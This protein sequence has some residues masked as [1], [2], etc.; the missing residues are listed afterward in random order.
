MIY[1]LR[2]T[3]YDFGITNCELRIGN[4]DYATISLNETDN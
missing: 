3:I 1:D 2:F 4:F